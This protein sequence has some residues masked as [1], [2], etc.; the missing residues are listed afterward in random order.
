MAM[1]YLIYERYQLFNVLEY[2]KKIFMAGQGDL[3]QDFLNISTNSTD[4]VMDLKYFKD[5]L[6]LD[7]A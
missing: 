1:G 3:V 2:M 4:S 7:G 6:L 5:C